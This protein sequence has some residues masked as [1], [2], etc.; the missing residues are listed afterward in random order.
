MLL[1][2]V[3]APTLPASAGDEIW[4]ARCV[5]D[6]DAFAKVAEAEVLLAGPAAAAAPTAAR[7]VE[8][9]RDVTG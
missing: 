8:V 3:L 6:C 4:S 1:L 2:N 7:N 5:H 9:V